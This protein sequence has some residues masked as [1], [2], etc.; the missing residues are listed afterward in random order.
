[1][2][3]EPDNEDFASVLAR[4]IAGKCAEANK[5]PGLE[6]EITQ[7]RTELLRL[8]SEARGWRTSILTTLSYPRGSEAQIRCL[9]EVG[10][11]V[12]YYNK[13]YPLPEHD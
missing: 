12:R 13:K 3:E 9:E 8:R 10:Q 1:M 5:V 6:L 11:D 4:G 2:P 7:L